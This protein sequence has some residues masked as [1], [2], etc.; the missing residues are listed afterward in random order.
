MAHPS[1]SDG[2]VPANVPV[3][4]NLTIERRTRVIRL[5]A[6]L[7]HAIVTTPVKYSSKEAKCADP[8]QARQDSP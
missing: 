3:W 5:L 4:A 1:A 7:A 2:H 8:S 6:E